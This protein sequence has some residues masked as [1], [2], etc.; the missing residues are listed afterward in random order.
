[1]AQLK[2]YDAGTST[3]LPILVGAQG[4]Q[5]PQGPG[6]ELPPQNGNSGKYLTTDGTTASWAPAATETPHPFAMIG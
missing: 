6:I 1:M 2:Y 3:W 4:V 5:G